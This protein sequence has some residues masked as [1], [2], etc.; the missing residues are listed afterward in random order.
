[1]SAA[2]LKKN[3]SASDSGTITVYTA[4]GSVN[5]GI[6]GTGN[7]IKVS[8]SAGSKSYTV[9]IY[10]DTSGD[11]KVS[12]LDLLQIK[13]HIVKASSLNGVYSTAADTSK[14]GKIGSLDLLQVK[15]HIVKASNIQQ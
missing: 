7:V 9:V 6:V 13:R 12:S 2:T 14:D 11:G 1:M 4:S 3:L 8:N 15:R 10:G 5:S